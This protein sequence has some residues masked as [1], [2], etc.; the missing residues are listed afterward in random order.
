MNLFS[1]S[2]QS[3]I[4]PLSPVSGNYIMLSEVL[5]Q[6]LEVFQS[7]SHQNPLYTTHVKEFLRRYSYHYVLFLKC[8]DC[9]LKMNKY[10][11]KGVKLVPVAYK[12]Y[13][14]S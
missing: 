11:F 10:Q 3:F 4:S 1:R 12:C 5:K 6:Y 14:N 9:C 13:K 8:D 2:K 7:Y